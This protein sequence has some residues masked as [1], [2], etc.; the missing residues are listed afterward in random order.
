MRRVVFNKKGG[1][2]KTTIVCNL[3]AL[4]AASGLRTLVIDTDPQ[5]NAT[6]HLLAKMDWDRTRSL[7]GLFEQSLGFQLFP[8]GPSN[9]VVKTPYENLDII[10]GHST[11]NI[12][13]ARIRRRD[14]QG[15]CRSSACATRR[16]ATRPRPPWM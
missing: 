11:E 10:P 9:Y 7:Y 4:S 14:T 6:Q 2:G 12:A 8:D 15:S 16:R 5:S 3:A 13:A 1:V